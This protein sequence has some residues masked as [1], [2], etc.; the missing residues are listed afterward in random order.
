M[1][2]DE[3]PP[4]ARHR[5]PAK[6]RSSGDPAFGPPAGSGGQTFRLLDFEKERGPI[7]KPP[8]PE[9]IRI[10]EEWLALARAGRF[11]VIA[12]IGVTDDGAMCERF[13][14][15]GST[16]SSLLTATRM[17]EAAFVAALLNQYT[18]PAGMVLGPVPPGNLDP[19]EGEEE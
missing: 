8:N 5:L 12:C 9:V 16:I 11:K 19:S 13:V 18:A 4:P 17:L 7:V 15:S 3:K 10:L 14:H 6:P 1:S 2:K